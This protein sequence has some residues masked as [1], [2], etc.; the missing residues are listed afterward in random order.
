MGKTVLTE[1][2]ETLFIPLY[3]KAIES[4]KKNSVL[5]D[6]K[7]V[8]IINNLD[9]DFNSLKIP[10]KTNVMM[11]LRAR[12]F[13]D[14]T[15]E[16]LRGH[17]QASV[18]HL[19]CGLDSRY[20]RIGSPEANWFDID[21]PDVIDLRKQFYKTTGF[22]RMIPSSVT[23]KEW[24]GNIPSS[25]NS[26]LIIAEGLFMYLSETGIRRLLS[27][28][29]EH[30]NS[31]YLIFDV[32]SKLTA[33]SIGSHPSMKKTDAKV[34]WGIDDSRTLE[35]WDIGAEYK[36]E[37]FFTGNR[38]MEKMDAGTKFMYKIAGLFPVAK[39][40]HRILVYKIS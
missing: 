25:G 14:F 4:G 22:Y 6:K 35:Y 38:A 8:E 18:V 7:A 40:A 33:K 19:G 34:Q 20:E 39:R 37:I 31:Y 24:I 21:F 36:D 27:N 2:K 10:A 13:D 30:L 12:L 11:C 16:F 23:E 28:L 26:D 1:E 9:Y 29:K 3:G 5:T 17:P 15:V 32:F